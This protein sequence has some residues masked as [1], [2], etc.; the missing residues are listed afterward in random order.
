[1]PK[2][3]GH[4]IRGCLI[5]FE[6]LLKYAQLGLDRANAGLI[7]APSTDAALLDAYREHL[8][9]NVVMRGHI[10]D[11]VGLIKSHYVRYLGEAALHAVVDQLMPGERTPRKVPIM[12]EADIVA[13]STSVSN[14]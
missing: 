2:S 9:T 11:A 14:H 3:C 10:P 5:S 4:L 12:P 7:I 1:M 8:G 6:S 13:L